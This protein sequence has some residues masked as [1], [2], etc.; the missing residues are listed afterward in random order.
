MHVMYRTRVQTVDMRQS[1]NWYPVARALQRKIIYHA[2]PT[3]SGKTYQALEV[4]LTM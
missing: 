2:G 3:N 1:H 4:Q